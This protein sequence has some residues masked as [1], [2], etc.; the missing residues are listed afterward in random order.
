MWMA[1]E[2]GLV[3]HRQ[4]GVVLGRV[5]DLNRAGKLQIPSEV[6]KIYQLQVASKMSDSPEWSASGDPIAGTGDPVS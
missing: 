2:I 3:A 1:T 6:S 5:L 4:G